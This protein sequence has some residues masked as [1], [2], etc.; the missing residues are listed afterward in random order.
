MR[1]ASRYTTKRIAA[2]SGNPEQTRLLEESERIVTVELSG[3]S[4]NVPAIGS[5][6]GI[7]VPNPEGAA[8]TLAEWGPS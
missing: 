3:W 6:E 2:D 4:A 8:T 1:R 7:S 5:M